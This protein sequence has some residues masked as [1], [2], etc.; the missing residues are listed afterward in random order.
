M[1]RPTLTFTKIAHSAPPHAWFGVSAIFHYLGPSFAVLLFP[2]VGVLGVAWMRIASAA[3]IFAPWTKP[4]RT[5]K[6]ADPRTR[7]LLI[8]LGACLAIMNTSFYLALDRLPMSLVAAIE[9][10]GTIGVALYGLRTARNFTALALA[11]LG[12]FLLIDVKWSTDPLGL[13]WASLNGALFVGYL[14]L[15]HKISEG[16]ASGGVERL[17]AA[18]AMA[19]FFVM[20]IGFVQAAEAFTMPVLVLAGVAVGACSSVIPYV[21]DQLAMSRLPR[22]SFALMLALLPATATLIGVMVLAQIPSGQDIIGVLFVMSG[23]AIHKPTVPEA[24]AQEAA[25]TAP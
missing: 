24:P 17:G 18:M 20:P 9:F 12:V 19:F 10:V 23:I 13:F 16:G 2:A 22:A 14:V 11:V 8:G 4:W 25:S 6:E 3:A 1:P 21:C 5:I 7:F 15:G